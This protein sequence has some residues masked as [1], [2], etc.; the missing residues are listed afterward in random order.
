MNTLFKA[1]PQVSKILDEI[2]AIIHA[3]NFKLENSALRHASHE[4]FVELINKKFDTIR[5]KIQ[6]KEII[7]IEEVE[8]EL[9][10]QNLI[11]EFENMLSPRLK[12]VINATGVVIHTNLGR[13]PLSKDSI[14]AI[15]QSAGQYSTVEF[16]LETG[17]R[18]SRHAIVK[19]LLVQITKA[20]DAIVVNNNAA[21]VMLVLSELAKGG[22]T[23]ISRGEL[24]EIGGSFRIPDVME[25][26]GSI[27]KDVGTTNK[28]HLADYTN[29]I[30]EET[31]AI[32]RVHTSNFRLIG[33]TSKVATE[34]LAILA[35]KNNI[36][37]I[38]DLGS[39]SFIDF[40]PYGLPAEPT[41]QEVVAQDVDVVTFSGDKLLGAPQAGIIVGK[42]IYIDKIRKNQ[43]LRA[44]RPCKLTLAGLEATLKA[45]LDIEKAKKEIPTLSMLTMDYEEIKK[46]ANKLAKILKEKIGNKADIIIKEDSSRVGGG[47]FPEAPLKTKLVTISPKNIS[48]SQLKIYL[49][50]SNPPI[51]GRLEDNCFALD[52]RTIKLEDYTIIANVLD[53]TI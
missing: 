47:A 34:D 13:S 25:C 42:K 41:V 53:K 27:L 9:E 28:T 18:G 46:R 8:K 19:D 3:Q 11:K 37:L 1:I 30:N 48:A 33:F 44:L 6:E 4:L 15:A 39:G 52:V 51:I 20:E 32:M 45:Y 43:L 35:H 10:I 12:P 36:P 14:Q 29:A 24:V 22:E 5:Q 16:D 40:T 21:A 26:S 7:K 31:K 23:V 38:E 49:L 2:Y 50:S 17:E